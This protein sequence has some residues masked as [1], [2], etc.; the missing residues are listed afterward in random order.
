MAATPAD[1]ALANRYNGEYAYQVWWLVAS[2]L[3]LVGVTHYGSIAL[4]KLFPSGKRSADIEAD[5]RVVRRTFSFRRFPF[6]IVNAYRVVAFRT[7][8]TI[9]PF[10]LNLTEVALTIA[11]IVALFV[12]S[13]T[14]S[15]HHGILS[16]TN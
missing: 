15:T 3:F 11:Y 14:N 12:R 4:R 1:K 7:T 6:T 8:L 10:S 13:F 9:G 2:F 16:C 5:C